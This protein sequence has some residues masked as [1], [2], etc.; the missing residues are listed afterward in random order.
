[1]LA[2][3]DC[4]QQAVVIYQSAPGTMQ[5][6]EHPQWGEHLGLGNAQRGEVDFLER[7]NIPIY[8]F[9][10]SEY[11][12]VVQLAHSRAPVPEHRRVLSRCEDGEHRA[13]DCWLCRQ[14]VSTVSAP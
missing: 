14:R 9:L 1:M 6:E 12:E 8:G 11:E 10:V 4:K 13:E 5:H 2:L 7:E 3:R